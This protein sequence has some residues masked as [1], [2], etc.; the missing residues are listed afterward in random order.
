VLRASCLFSFLRTLP[1]ER[2]WAT[3]LKG[4]IALR[5]AEIEPSVVRE[6]GGVSCQRPCDIDAIGRSH[7][8]PYHRSHES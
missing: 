4:E 8:Y 3:P 1:E 6:L 2:M 5:E 7:V